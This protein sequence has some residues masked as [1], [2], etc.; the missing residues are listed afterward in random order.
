[1]LG[2]ILVIVEFISQPEYKGLIPVLGIVNEGACLQARDGNTC[3]L[4][5]AYLP[6]I[7]RDVLASLYVALPFLVSFCCSTDTTTQLPPSTQHEPR[8]HRL[9]RGYG[10]FISIHDG[11]QGTA[12]WAGFLLESDR[13]ILDDTYMGSCLLV[14]ARRFAHIFVHTLHLSPR[15]SRS[16]VLY[17]SLYNSLFLPYLTPVSLLLIYVSTL[18]SFTRTY[19]PLDYCIVLSFSFLYSG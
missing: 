9:R 15:S 14:F 11:F 2:Y 18:L 10:P 16:I 1:M 12:S 7:G 17:L 13:I 3:P 4:V 5:T 8:H 6:G 19:C